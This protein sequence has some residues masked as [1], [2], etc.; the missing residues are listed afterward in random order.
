MVIGGPDRAS[1]PLCSPE[2]WGPA[3]GL[4]PK[5]VD[6]VLERALLRWGWLPSWPPPRV[7]FG[8]YPRCRALLR[9]LGVTGK[10]LCS[11]PNYLPE[12]PL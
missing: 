5:G 6:S 4:D 9:L 7:L 3:R 1:P 11:G 12:G 10:G 2:G 8:P